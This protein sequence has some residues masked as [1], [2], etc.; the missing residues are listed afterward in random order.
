MGARLGIVFAAAVSDLF[1]GF[2][3]R[4]V[5]GSRAGAVLDP[6]CDKLFM[7][8]AFVVVLTSGRLALVEVIGVVLRD[9]TAAVTFLGTV[10]LR[11]PMA[12]PVRAGG[13][14]VTVFQVLTLIAFAAESDMIRPLAWVAAAISVYAIV[15]YT[16]AALQS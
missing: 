2:W 3:A 14:A 12:L 7:A 11:R 13:K 16:R 9:L 10:L 15:D 5:G 6:V 4:R 8:A 1:D